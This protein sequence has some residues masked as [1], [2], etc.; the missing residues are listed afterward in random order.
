MHI[1]VYVISHFQEVI[2]FLYVHICTLYKS[3]S[4]FVICIGAD[5]AQ[6]TFT[7]ICVKNILKSLLYVKHTHTHIHTH[8]K[9]LDDDFQDI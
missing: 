7:P 8:L 6:L 1:C 3:F 2:I 4:Y 5:A 9:F